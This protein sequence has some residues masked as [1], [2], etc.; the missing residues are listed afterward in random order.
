[1][2]R[3]TASLIVRMHEALVDEGIG[4]ADGG[5]PD[6]DREILQSAARMA[7]AHGDLSVHLAW[8]INLITDRHHEQF[9]KC[10]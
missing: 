9:C 6:I 7:L 8:D 3:E 1:M 2:D 5:T 4:P 10:Q